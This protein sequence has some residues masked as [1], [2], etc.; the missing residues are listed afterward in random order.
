MIMPDELIINPYPYPDVEDLLHQSHGT[1]QGT[2]P[3]AVPLSVPPRVIKGFAEAVTNAWRAKIRMLDP[4]T[5]DV[6]EEMRRVY[7]HVEATLEVFVGLGIQ[8]KDHTGETFDY[9]SALKVITTQ[10]TPGILQESVIETIKPTVY[11]NQQL[12]QIGEVVIA[13]PTNPSTSTSP[14]PSEQ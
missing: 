10:P 8:L 3:T 14:S 13:T 6:R 5:G 11:W 2:H 4:V 1:P 7:R 9:G 12:I